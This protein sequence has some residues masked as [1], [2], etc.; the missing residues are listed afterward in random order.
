MNKNILKQLN[1][2]KVASL[3]LGLLSVSKRNEI[4]KNLANGLE[5]NKKQIIQA[6]RKDLKNFSISDPMRDRLLLDESRIDGMISEIKSLIKMPDPIGQIYDCKERFGMKICRKKVPLGVIGIIYES[7]PNVT[8]DVASICIKSGNASVLK[9]GKEA[10]NS[11][12]ALHKIIR[13]SFIKSHANPDAVQFMDPKQ[14]DAVLD[15]I[16]GRGLVDVIIPRGSANLINFVREN[17]KVPVIETGAGVC[18]TFVDKSAKLDLSA[19]IIF[20]AKTQRP[21]VCNALDT[22]LIHRDIAKNFLPKMAELLLQKNVE[23]FADKESYEILEKSYPKNLLKKA[24]SSDFGREF[25]SQK[26]SVKIVKDI[27]GAIAHITK[28]SSKHSE[29]ILSE[30][31]I[32][33]ERF[34]NEI[35]S[36]VV[37]VNASTRFS[38]GAVFGLGSEIGISTDKIHAR[39][40]MGPAE[41]TTYKW[42][43]SG[44]YNTRGIKSTKQNPNVCNIC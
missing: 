20:N 42:I 16:S 19:E 4:L 24:K 25:L 39:G 5:K 36:A 37:Y 27:D 31:K 9:G 13:E 3:S 2:A 7:R 28:Y 8:T 10:R 23:I 44:N 1:N 26:M 6:N 11:Y 33:C 17:S 14:K 21:S 32:N 38:D 30:N 34:L 35:D 22:A 18:H 12:I 41:M 15:I 40:P 43:V 29:A